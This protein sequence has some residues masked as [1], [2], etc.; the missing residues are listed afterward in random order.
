MA[1]QQAKTKSTP[2]KATTLNLFIIKQISKDG[3]KDIRGGI[4]MNNGQGRC[5]G[6]GGGGGGAC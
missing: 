5:C 4:C 2:K 3:L 1:K 6:S